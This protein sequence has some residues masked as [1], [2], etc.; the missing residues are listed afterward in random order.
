MKAPSLRTLGVSAFLLV[1]AA[2]RAAWAQPCSN[3]YLVQQTFASGGHQTEWMICWQTP[4][5]W[6]LVITTA[7]FRKAANAPWVRVFW[8]ARVSEIF[9]PYHGDGAWSR[10]MDLRDYIKGPETLTAGDCPAAVGGMLLNGVVCREVHDRGLAWKSDAAVYRGRE[11]V[12]WGS[13]KA[14]N[15]RYIIKWTFRDDGVVLGEMAATGANLPTQPTNAHAHSA[16]WRLDIDLNGA[17]NDGVHRLVHSEPGL[18]ATD[19]W[20]PVNQEQQ[21]AW[22][23]TEATTLHIQD[24]TF[25]NARGSASGYMLSAIRTTSLHHQEP[26]TRDFWVTRYN[27][28]EMR[29]HELPAYVAAPQPTMGQDIVVWY[30]GPLHHSYREEDGV[31]SDG[32][33]TGVAQTMWTGFMLKPHNL[34]DQVPFFP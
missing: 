31:V 2:P 1:A 14:A 20:S 18:V 13:F 21:L 22:N 28:A 17:A 32:T 5:A 8:D 34:F 16:M 15:Y 3:P 19:A 24:P 6:G 11:L 9:V 10:Y 33:F 4:D 27:A 23:P 30:W 7:F 25:K 26:W 29:P 12:L